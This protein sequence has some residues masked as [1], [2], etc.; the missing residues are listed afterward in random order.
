MMVCTLRCTSDPM[1]MQ[2]LSIQSPLWN[3]FWCWHEAASQ[4]L[5]AVGGKLCYGGAL[6]GGSL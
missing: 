2:W 3:G 6:C 4:A 1:L 5:A